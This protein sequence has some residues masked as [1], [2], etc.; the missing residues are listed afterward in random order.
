MKRKEQQP[1]LEKKYEEGPDIDFDKEV[2]LDNNGERYTNA[3]IDAMV[4]DIEEHGPYV[5]RPSLTAPTV[6]SPE[7][8]ARVP[9]PLKEKLEATAQA[10]GETPSALIRQAVEEFLTRNS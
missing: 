2:V 3:R 9:A 7:I 6:H 10:R 8:K 1:V 4:R 5:G